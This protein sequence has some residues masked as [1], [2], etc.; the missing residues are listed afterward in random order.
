MDSQP[1]LP[2]CIIPRNAELDELEHRLQHSLVVYVGGAWPRVSR[3]QV[4]E[5]IISKANVPR[6]TFSVHYYKPEDFLVVFSSGELRRQVTTLP[7]LKH[8]HFTL[9]YRPWTRLA[10][11]ERRVARSRVI[12][13]L[14]GIPPH[15]WARTTVE[16]L[17]DTSCTVEAIAPETADRS[18]MGTFRLTGWTANEE[19]VPPE[20]DLWVPEPKNFVLEEAIPR[21]AGRDHERGLLRYRAMCKPSSLPLQTVA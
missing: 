9:F 11:A 12:V 20:R 21:P 7:S 14:E 17:L 19:L 10:Q 3:E 1:R 8:A 2:P 18:D 5:A 16:H 13:A 15:A 6:G 4:T